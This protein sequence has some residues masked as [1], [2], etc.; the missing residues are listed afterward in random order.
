MTEERFIITQNGD[1]FTVRDI[2]KKRP[3]GMFEFKEDEFPVY[4][5]FHKIID[6]LNKLNDENEQ[7]KDALK[8]RTEQCDKYYKENERLK[9][10]RFI[11]L[12]CEHSGYTEIGC[13][14]E[15]TDHWQDY[16]TE[17]EDFK[18]LRE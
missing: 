11:C 5:C 4:F 16:I 12:D 2:V 10:Y 3:L 7:L 13:L 15:Y 9:K 14:C 8:Q 17:C 18:E 1:L 6:L